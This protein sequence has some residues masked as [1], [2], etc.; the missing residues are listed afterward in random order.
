VSPDLQELGNRLSAE[1]RLKVEL[2]GGGRASFL[3]VRSVRRAVEISEDEGGL[4]IEYWD[5]SDELSEA[6]AVRS[7]VVPP[8]EDAFKKAVEWL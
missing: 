4:F 5:T 6:P 2:R 7:E 3:Y 8:S 1:A